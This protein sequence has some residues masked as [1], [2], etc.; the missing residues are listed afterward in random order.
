MLICVIL[1]SISWNDSN[2]LT[3]NLLKKLFSI[4]FSIFFVVI[5]NMIICFIANKSNPFLIFCELLS[6]FLFKQPGVCFNFYDYM[7]LFARILFLSSFY[8]YLF[9]HSFIFNSLCRTFNSKITWDCIVGYVANR[10]LIIRRFY[11]CF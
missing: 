8:I 7:Q 6:L 11:L 2:T 9:S 3:C 5:Y 10:L 1:S 4:S